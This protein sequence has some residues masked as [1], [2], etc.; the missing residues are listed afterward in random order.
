MNCPECNREMQRFK[1][2]FVFNGKTFWSP[3]FHEWVPQCWECDH[4]DLREIDLSGEY[5]GEAASV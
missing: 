1:G 2:H 4:C 3:S 5:I